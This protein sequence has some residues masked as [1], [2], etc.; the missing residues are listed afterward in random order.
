MDRV[1]EMLDYLKDEM[2]E[3]LARFKQEL[4]QQELFD[5]AQVREALEV[6]KAEIEAGEKAENTFVVITYLRSSYITESHQFKIA[7]YEDEPFVEEAIMDRFVDL[8]QLYKQEER[9]PELID[10]L[11]RKIRLKFIRVVPYEIEEVRRFYME[12]LYKNSSFFFKN[13]VNEMGTG[14][15]GSVKNIVYFGEE[16]G[17]IEE[18]GVI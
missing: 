2:E 18:I 7:L 9:I 8:T 13:I 14:E 4:S 11:T 5:E 10:K 17:K 3:G 1:T 12:S 6:M 15:S 16:M